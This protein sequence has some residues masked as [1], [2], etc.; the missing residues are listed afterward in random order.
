MTSL[1]ISKISRK[2]PCAAGWFG[3]KFKLTFLML[4]LLFSLRKLMP[5]FNIS[6]NQYLVVPWAH[7]PLKGGSIPLTGLKVLWV[8]PPQWHFI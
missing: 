8:F 5:L 4:V 2:T 7:Y 1:F 6:N 3:P